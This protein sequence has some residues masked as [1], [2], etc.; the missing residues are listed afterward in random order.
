MMGVVDNF[1][2]VCAGWVL[3]VSAPLAVAQTVA[4]ELRGPDEGGVPFRLTD[5]RGQVVLVFAWGSGCP[6][7]LHAMSEFRAN[8]AGWRN[9]PFRLV[10][11]NT[12]AHDRDLKNWL[13]I[14]RQVQQEALRWPTL[15]AGA[16][17]FS[18]TLNFS[19]SLPAVWVLDKTGVVRLHVR[20]RMPA[21]VW[22]EVADLL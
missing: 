16:P 14:R 9:S 17:G 3:A 1:L 10:A 15:W 21:E 7:C 12:D 19:G 20:G 8:A 6:V 22:N 13:D 5:W 4:P 2:K 11:V 18:S